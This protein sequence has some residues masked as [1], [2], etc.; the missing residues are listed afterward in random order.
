MLAM[1]YSFTLPASFAMDEIRQRIATKGPLLDDFPGLVFKAYLYACRGDEGSENLY[2]PFYLWEDADAMNRFLT[3]P[4]FVAVSESFGWP[5]VRVW[6]VLHARTSP[7]LR[8]A[9]VATR[10]LEQVAPHSALA[11][12]QE[13]AI[14]STNA[15]IDEGHALAAV[16]AYEPTTWTT[17]RFALWRAAPSADLPGQRYTVGHVSAPDVA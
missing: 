17:V 16:T 10:V 1:Q 9:A 4:G 12:M 13:Q 6:P 5:V 11:G 3:G 8:G 7:G 14:A 15:A 2:A